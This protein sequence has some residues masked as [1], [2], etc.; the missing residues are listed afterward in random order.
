[1]NRKLELRKEMLDKQK[2]IP[3]EILSRKSDEIQKQI[4]TSRN[5]QEA[6]RIFLFVSMKN[7]VDTITIMV[8]AWA[9][10]KE[11]FVPITE[12]K[13]EMY[14]VLLQSLDELYPTIFGVLEPRKGREWEDTPRKEDLFLVPGVV[15]DQKGNRIGYG[16]GF[17]DRYFARTQPYQKIGI[18]FSFQVIEE[19][20]PKEEFD[21]AVDELLTENEWRR[22][23]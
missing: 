9:D 15:F 10:G 6:K 4:F 14:F 21:I 16:G 5:Y 17:Y 2:E 12:K 18:V 1:M 7:E 8:K 22:M 11:V 13:G 3:L 20:I 19:E 23:R